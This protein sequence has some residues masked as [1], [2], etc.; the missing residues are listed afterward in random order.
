MNPDIKLFP[1][2]TNDNKFSVELSHAEE[3]KV[4]LYDM[5]GRFLHQWNNLYGQAEFFWDFPV[6]GI[7]V[8]E[9]ETLTRG[10]GV[11]QLVVE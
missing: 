2:P 5:S 1:N 11:Y 7:Y 3:F 8:V 4:R 10:R 9:I 6:T